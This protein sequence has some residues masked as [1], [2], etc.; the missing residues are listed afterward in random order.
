[1][2]NELEDPFGLDANDM[3]MVDFHRGFCISLYETLSQPW[4][5][6]D[7]WHVA[8]GPWKPG[9]DRQPSMNGEMPQHCTSRGASKKW[10]LVRRT[11]KPAEEP[12]AAAAI[13]EAAQAL[14]QTSPSAAGALQRARVSKGSKKRLVSQGEEKAASSSKEDDG[15]D[16]EGTQLAPV[17]AGGQLRGGPF[18]AVAPLKSVQQSP[19]PAAAAGI[20][21]DP[22]VPP[23]V[24]SPQL[25]P[26]VNVPVD[27]A[28]LLP[29][30]GGASCAAASPACSTKS[31]KSTDALLP[32]EPGDGLHTDLPLSPP[33][34]GHT[35]PPHRVNEP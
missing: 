28:A 24:G 19:P 21:M 30:R 8:K 35:S 32:N 22:P 26:T 3:P 12:P 4:M 1:M 20:G 7:T 13:R 29:T 16:K 5:A 11:V 10:G 23:G 34:D 17:K 14:Q 31:T 18:V 15:S 33:W 2:A 25:P 6:S 27:I 9:S